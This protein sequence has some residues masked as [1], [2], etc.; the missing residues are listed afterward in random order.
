MLNHN[1]ILSSSHR[2]QVQCQL[3]QMQW[4]SSGEVIMCLIWF[5]IILFLQHYLCGGRLSF[6]TMRT[7]VWTKMIW[8]LIPQ[9]LFR[10]NSNSQTSSSMCLI[11]GHLRQ[12]RVYWQGSN[13]WWRHRL[14]RWVRRV[15]MQWV[16]KFHHWKYN[17]FEYIWCLDL[18]KVSTSRQQLHSFNISRYS[19][20]LRNLWA[21][22]DKRK[23]HIF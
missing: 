7:M 6:G 14:L 11:W 13:L 21:T 12:R 19:K 9:Q 22:S 8:W 1:I 23:S 20:Y 17:Y 16:F 2:K 3:Q 4:F 10:D 15:I 18:T 5:C